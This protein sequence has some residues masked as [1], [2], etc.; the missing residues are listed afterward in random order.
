MPVSQSPSGI[1][2]VGNGQMVDASLGGADVCVDSCN[3]SVGT[4]WGTDVCV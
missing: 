3:T 4:A 2:Q 1:T